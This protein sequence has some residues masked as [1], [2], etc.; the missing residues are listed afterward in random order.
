MSPADTHVADDVTDVEAYRRGAQDTG[1]AAGTL[2]E[3][4]EDFLAHCSDPGVLGTNDLVG[5]CAN[6][7]YAVA[8]TWVGKC[9]RELAGA[10]DD[11]AQALRQT[12]E[13]HA[14]T[15]AR[16]TA[17]ARRIDTSGGPGEVGEFEAPQ[18]SRTTAPDPQITDRPGPGEAPDE[19]PDPFADDNAADGYDEAD[20]T[21][22][23]DGTDETSSI[24]GTDDPSATKDTDASVDPGTGAAGMDAAPMTGPPP[25]GPLSTGPGST[26]PTAAPAGATPTPLN[27]ALRTLS[28]GA[29]TWAT[30][31][32][33]TGSAAGPMGMPMS[34]AGR[35]D[36]RAAGTVVVKEAADE[37][38]DEEQEK[39]VWAG[40]APAAKEDDR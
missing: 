33:E 31:A 23:F 2:T 34:G 28:L 10:Y 27:G 18:V 13:Q 37:D 21:D 9:L 15:E 22:G 30:P 17:T 5:R 29:P 12:A 1:A 7:M 16:N 4:V 32:T 14:E 39:S 6:P 38:T 36:R 3:Q 20:G 35:D 11:H 24:D 40:L 26:A 19:L 8:I 25:T